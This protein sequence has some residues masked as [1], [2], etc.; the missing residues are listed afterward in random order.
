MHREFYEAGYRVFGLN[1]FD[2]KTGHCHCENPHCKAP[3]KHPISA[4]WQYTPQWSESQ[5]ETSE[6][7]GHFE[8]GYGVLCQGLLVIDVDARN[9]GVASFAKLCEDIPEIMGA[10]LIVETGSGGGS[11]HLYFSLPNDGKAYLQHLTDYKGVDFKTSGFVVGPGSNHISGGIYKAVVGSPHDIDNAP[12]KLLSLLRRPDR[13]VSVVNGHSVQVAHEDIVQML[14]YIDPDCAHDVWVSVGMAIH[15]STGGTG[16]ELWDSWSA[17][18]SKYPDSPT[19]YKRWHSFGKSANPVTLGTLVHHAENGG[20]VMPISIA[21]V[22]GVC[23]D[24]PIKKN[25]LPMDISGVDLTRPPGFV[26]KVAEWINSQCRKPREVLAVGSALSVV[27]NAIGMRYTDA[28]DRVSANLFVFGVAG[29][30]TGKESINKAQTALHMAMGFGPATHGLLKSEQEVVKNIIRHQ[31]CFLLMDEIGIFMQKLMNSSK[32]GAVYL[33]GVIGIWMSVYSKAD[34]AFLVSGDMKETMKLKI[35]DM[36]AAENRR[37]EPNEEKIAVL[38]KGLQSVD[39]GIK[40]PFL[41]LMGFT[42]PETFSHLVDFQSAANGFFGRALLFIEHDTTPRAKHNFTNPPP[43]LPESIARTLNLLVSGG[44][45]SVE[46]LT[47]IEYLG[48]KVAIPTNDDAA[49]ALDAVADYFQDMA[50]EIKNTTGLEAL[51]L[52]AYEHVSKISL[53]LGAPEH[54]RTIEH[55]RWAFALVK[56][57]IEHK[58]MMVI[59]NDRQ[60]DD[61]KTALMARVLNLCSGDDG[62]TLGVL[63]NRCR[64]KSR[65]DVQ[66]AIDALIAGG[67]LELRDFVRADTKRR[68]ERYFAVD[69][70]NYTAN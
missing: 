67:H 57:D 13:H 23:F 24:E 9:G 62:E 53:I 7:M 32:S 2:A 3:G 46:P 65:A 5:L 18:G 45:Y 25:G 48:E 68:S 31:A 16:F 30:G 17:K 55:V 28:K 44:S 52:R 37:N 40:R 8:S 69:T 34:G 39:D 20:W 41:S 56:R 26:G 60:K 38:T 70:S 10:G 29:S 11:K 6:K 47:R 49:K 50:E 59:S 12:D 42:T 54:V 33:E 15:H 14:D 64:P 1:G 63:F 22:E 43:E 27:S 35:M 61:P 4:G 51:P 66:M 19:L 36:I 21:P 58:I